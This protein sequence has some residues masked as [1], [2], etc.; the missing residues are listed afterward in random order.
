MRKIVGFLLLSTIIGCAKMME[1]QPQTADSSHPPTDSLLTDSL[2]PE[3][4][5]SM[6]PERFQTFYSEELTGTMSSTSGRAHTLNIETILDVAISA[7]QEDVLFTLKKDGLDIMEKPSSLWKGRLVP[8]RYMIA[9]LP[10]PSASALR[11]TPYT[12]SIKE[13]EVNP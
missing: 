12:I 5:G 8:G 4:P 7:E 3:T 2:K 11:A 9:V 13:D 1:D 10:S 6:I